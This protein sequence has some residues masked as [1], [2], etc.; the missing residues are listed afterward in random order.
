M[1]CP[2]SFDRFQTATDPTAGVGFAKSHWGCFA[3]GERVNA[4]TV[5]AQTNGSLC[6]I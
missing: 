6:C 4:G 2:E 5:L 3:N 1:G